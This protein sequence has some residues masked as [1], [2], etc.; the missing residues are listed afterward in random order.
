[1]SKASW[2]ILWFF[3][4]NIVVF[5]LYLQWSITLWVNVE[6]FR[7]TL[8]RCSNGSINDKF[9]GSNESM[10]SVIDIILHAL[11]QCKI[12]SVNFYGS[13]TSSINDKCIGSRAML[14]DPSLFLFFSVLIWKCFSSRAAAVAIFRKTFM[15]TWRRGLRR[16]CTPAGLV[17]FNAQLLRF[18][19]AI[20]EGKE[21]GRTGRTSVHYPAG[22]ASPLCPLKLCHNKPSACFVFVAA[23]TAPPAV[24][25]VVAASSLVAVVVAASPFAVVVVVV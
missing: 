21:T 5:Y 4:L 12:F 25:V 17:Q 14:I 20:V 15:N 23:T 13:R 7:W 2:M 16:A 9:V 11:T 10:R 1:M 22:C 8:H 3:F 24:V 18:I 19:W 6:D